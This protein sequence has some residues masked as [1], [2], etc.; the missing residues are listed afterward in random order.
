MYSLRQDCDF[1]SKKET[2][3]AINDPDLGANGKEFDYL[4]LEGHAK[5]NNKLLQNKR[6]RNFIISNSTDST[7]SPFPPLR[8]QVFINGT[9]VDININ[10]AIRRHMLTLNNMLYDNSTKVPGKKGEG[11]LNYTKLLFN[12]IIS[13]DRPEQVARVKHLYKK[14]SQSFQT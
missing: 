5:L 9:W 4:I 13:D 7:Q 8:G 11:H 10:D 3:K 1:A 12:K 6:N 2:L 14:I